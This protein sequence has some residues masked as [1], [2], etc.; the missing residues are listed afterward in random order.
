MKTDL[1]NDLHKLIDEIDD[2]QALN[3][4][5]EEAAV[6]AGKKDILDDFSEDELKE[7]D[8][9]IAEADKGEAVSYEEYKKIVA[10]WLTK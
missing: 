3:I 6:Y 7:L 1:K 2:E 4:L 5:K 8:E 9:A 10:G